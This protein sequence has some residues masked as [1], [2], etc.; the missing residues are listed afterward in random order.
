MEMKQYEQYKNAVDQ[1]LGTLKFTSPQSLYTPIRYTLQLPAKRLRPV[2]T[3]ISA[4]MA[5][6]NI[7]KALPASLAVELF[8]NFTLLHDDIMDEAPIRRGKA[9]V[10]YQF[11]RDAAILSGDALLISAYRQLEAYT[12]DIQIE[13]FKALNH[14]ALSVCEGQQLDME[15]ETNENVALTEYLKMIGL[16]TAHLIGASMKMGALTAACS[17][18]LADAYFQIGLNMGMAFQI[19][20][21]WLDTFGELH[22]FGKK[23]GGDIVRNKKTFL[24]LSAMEKASEPQKKLL[25]DLLYNQT[26]KEEDKIHSVRKLYHDL[27]IDSVTKSSIRKYSDQAII[28]IEALQ[29]NQ[30]E[31]KVLIDILNQLTHRNR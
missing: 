16:K 5:G 10:F 19:Q 2:L 31:T 7:N 13:L 26:L 12:S 29:I 9:S 20:D 3:L 22:Q 28:G 21:D 18:A 23:R 1:A 14:S 24:L 30:S 8:H 11:G 25:H 4:E 15:F 17:P 6:G 27:D